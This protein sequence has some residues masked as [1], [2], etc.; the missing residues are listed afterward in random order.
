MIVSTVSVLGRGCGAVG[1][2]VAS[3]TRDPQI[4][5]QHQQQFI[6]FSAK[7]YLNLE[8]MKINEKVAVNGPF[9]KQQFLC[10]F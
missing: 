7:L 6:C 3:D 8:K 10:Q 5:S 1:R 9:K 2:A 4:E